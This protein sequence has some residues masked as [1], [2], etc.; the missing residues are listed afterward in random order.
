MYPI[1]VVKTSMLSLGII[2]TG[3]TRSRPCFE[4]SIQRAFNPFNVVCY[5]SRARKVKDVL[6]ERLGLLALARKLSNISLDPKKNVMGSAAPP[7]A[8][9]I[10]TR[11]RPFSRCH[12]IYSQHL[13]IL[14]GQNTP[15]K[16]S[17]KPRRYMHAG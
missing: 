13:C 9:L 15:A 10:R 11:R 6:S 17:A 1:K 7:L 14:A 3:S 16:P 2:S 5:L 4:R 12:K 8:S